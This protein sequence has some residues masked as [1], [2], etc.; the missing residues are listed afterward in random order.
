MDQ[1]L[2]SNRSLPRSIPKVHILQRRREFLGADGADHRLQFI[3]ALAVDADGVALNLRGYLELAVADEAGD[4]FGDGLVEALFDF[5]DLAGMA[6]RRNVGLGLLH[7][8]E[9][10]TAFGQLAQD[11]FGQSAN[12]ELIFSGELDFVF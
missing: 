5:N 11:D 4:L 6:E 12:L 2:S 7:T 9:A 1:M 10:D 8:F 3:S